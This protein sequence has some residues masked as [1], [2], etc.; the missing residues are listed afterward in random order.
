MKKVPNAIICASCDAVHARVELQEH[1]VAWCQRCGLEIDRHHGKQNDRMLPLTVAGLIIF[2][3]AHVFPIVEIE[4][5]G[6]HSQTTLLSVVIALA[7]EGMVLVAL[8][9]LVTTLL[10]PLLQMLMLLWLLVPLR[11]QQRAV[12]LAWLV[13][14]MQMLR[15]WGMIEIFLLGV[16]IALI[17]L[18]SMAI[19]LPGPA[20]WAFVALTVLLTVVTAFDPRS[21][22]KMLGAADTT[23]PI[24]GHGR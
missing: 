22:W 1:E 10:F 17:K 20:L 19:V 16:L 12:G 2:T 7:S 8:L 21:L 11:R 5:R 24:E 14:A 9:V 6:L 15:P 13:R 3:I 4:L 23:E 18:S